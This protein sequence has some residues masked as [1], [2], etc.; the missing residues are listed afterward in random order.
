M[1]FVKLITVSEGETKFRVP[2][3]EKGAG[4]KSVGKSVFYNPAMELNRDISISLLKA[5]PEKKKRV[6]DGMTATGARGVRI[7]NEVDLDDLAMIDKSTK[8]VKLAK[9]N[10]ESIGLQAKVIHDTIQSH[11]SKSNRYYNFID[12]DPFGTPVPFIPSAFCNIS[13]GGIVAVTA[14]DTAVLCGTYPV[15]CRRIYSSDPKNNWCRHEIGLR[16]LI[17]HC[18]RE[19]ARYD[20]AIRPLLSYYQG[21]HF[22]TYL[23][24]KDGAR[25]ANSC[26]DKLSLYEFDEFSWSEDGPTG[27]LWSGKLHDGNILDLMNPVGRMSKDMIELWKKESSFPPFFYDTNIMGSVFGRSPPS[28]DQMIVGL[29]DQGYGA[30]KTHFSPTGLK[31]KAPAEKVR[32]VFNG[33]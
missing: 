6:L 21:H 32:E 33:L 16:I 17:S 29:K 14:T 24:V 1:N 28:L 10:I 13:H 20:R 25:R 15:K 31:T 18:V 26:L 2:E 30:I 27:P 4:P 3:H 22:R 9:E 11:L 7:A 8:A 12:I 23:E 19:S 5:W